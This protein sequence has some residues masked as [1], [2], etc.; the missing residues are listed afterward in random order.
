MLINQ[1]SGRSVTCRDIDDESVN[2]SDVKAGS[3]TPKPNPFQLNLFT[4]N[5][6]HRV[7]QLSATTTPESVDFTLLDSERPDRALEIGDARGAQNSI[8]VLGA[9][10]F[11]RAPLPASQL[12]WSSREAAHGVGPRAIPIGAAGSGSVRVRGRKPRWNSSMRRARASGKEAVATARAGAATKTVRGG[13]LRVTTQPAPT[14]APS[15]MRTVLPP[16]HTTTTIGPTNAARPT[17]ILPGPPVWA[18]K[19]DRALKCAS[20]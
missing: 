1:R 11:P 6:L 17:I 3:H 9:Y 7:C 10:S 19:S 13:I 15:P 2:L 5:T 14:T 18:I 16:E 20:S 4:T 8:Q 12:P